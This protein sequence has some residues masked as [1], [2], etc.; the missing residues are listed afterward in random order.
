MSAT[1]DPEMLAVPAHLV[2]AACRAIS[3]YLP[4]LEDAARNPV[5]ATP[6]ML[7]AEIE[8]MRTAKALLARCLP[9]EKASE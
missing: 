4:A 5:I 8:Q 6:A 9:A 7:A 3:Y 1:T 2:A